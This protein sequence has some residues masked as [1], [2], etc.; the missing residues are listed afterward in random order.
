MLIDGLRRSDYKHNVT[1]ILCDNCHKWMHI[2]GDFWPE[3]NGFRG[4]LR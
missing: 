3:S 4:T 1:V 2:S